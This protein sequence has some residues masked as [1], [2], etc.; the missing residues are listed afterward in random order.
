MG[1]KLRRRGGG[2]VGRRG[3]V[4]WVVGTYVGHRAHVGQD[5]TGRGEGSE[6]RGWSMRAALLSYSITGVY[7]NEWA[8]LRYHSNEWAELRYHSNEW[9]GL[10]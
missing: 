9:A 8:G 1:A 5:R 2:D 7:S 4:P 3:G 6:V 10:Q